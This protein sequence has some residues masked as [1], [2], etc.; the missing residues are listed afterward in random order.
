MVAKDCVGFPSRR[1]GG[2]YQR[3]QTF[4]SEQFTQAGLRGVAT[5]VQCVE[6]SAVGQWSLGTGIVFARFASFQAMSLASVS[7]S[8]GALLV[9]SHASRSFL[10]S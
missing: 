1:V 8:A 3:I 9:C 10:N 5:G 6:I 7:R 4:S 2:R